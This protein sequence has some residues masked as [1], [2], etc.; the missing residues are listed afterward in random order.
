VLAAT[1]EEVVPVVLV[2]IILVAWAVLLGPSLLK[3]R[4]RSGGDQSIT[5]FHRQLR[6]LEHSAPELLVAPA[7]RLRA[8]DDHGMPTTITYPD[9]SAPP[10]LTVVGAKELPRPALAF[11]GAS[12]VDEVAQVVPEAAP[13]VRDEPA[14]GG[15]GGRD[16]FGTRDRYDGYELAGPDERRAL[17]GRPRPPS[18]QWT[19][20][21]VPLVAYDDGQRAEGFAG[22][23][24]RRRR[25]DTLAVL[26]AVF[27]TALVFAAV[28][29]VTALW[30]VC[31]VDAVALAAYVAL[32]AHMQRLAVE[33][34]RKLHYLD[35]SDGRDGRRPALLGGL[36]THVSGRYAH[37]SNQQAIAR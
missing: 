8:L 13:T 9:R 4:A 3:R 19:G 29:G 32:L 17:P 23:Q 2:I 35:G 31:A 26:V 21:S 10:K 16:V 27:L 6:I 36:P 5:H 24:A 37:P 15:R 1:P 18:D 20:P 11:L 25:R 14:I 7:Y 28:S 33:R 34:E 12:A 30:A 22:Q